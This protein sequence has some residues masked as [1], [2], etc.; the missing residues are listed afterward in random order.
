RD[1]AITSLVERHRAQLDPEYEQPFTFDE[2][3]DAAV[4]YLGWAAEDERVIV[5]P[6]LTALGLERAQIED[7]YY[8][9]EETDMLE[10][11]YRALR[12]RRPSARATLA[13]MRARVATAA[14]ATAG[15]MRTKIADLDSQ[16]RL[17]G[18]PEGALLIVQGPP[19]ACKTT[20]EI[21]LACAAREQGYHVA[22]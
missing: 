5:R 12:P 16:M 2:R 22:F 17:G 4:K 13:S 21:E 6:H 15:V 9:E 1:A 18:I 3:L 20:V 10:N 11:F 8:T 14:E 7:L 19:K